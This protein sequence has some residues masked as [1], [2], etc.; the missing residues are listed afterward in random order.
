MRINKEIFRLAIP[1]IITNITIPLLG[2]IDITIA[3]HMGNASFI[4]AIAV[5]AMMFNLVY[6]NMAFL[7]MGT[8][9]LTA[10][11]FGK[12]DKDGMKYILLRSSLIGLLIGLLIIALQYPLQWI[13]LL[14]ISPSNEVIILAQKY[15]YICVWGAPAILMTMAIKGW[16]LGMQNSKYP[17]YISIG[18]NIL[19]IIIS[20]WAV[21]ILEL[22]FIGI[23]IGTVVA[24]YLGI[25]FALVLLHKKYKYII[26]DINWSKCLRGND[27]N[28]FFSVNRDIFIR[29]LCLMSVTLFFMAVGARSGDLILAVNALIMQLFVMFSYFMDGFAFAGEA[30]VGRFAGA[31]NHI[32]IKLTIRNLFYWATIITVIFVIAY[33]YGN[34]EIFGFLTDDNSI[35]DVA[36]NYTCWIVLIP[37]AGVSAFIWDG[38]FIGLTATKQMV[39]SILAATAMFFIAFFVFPQESINDRLWLAFILYLAMR[40]ISQWALY[41]FSIRSNAQ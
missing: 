32:A 33:G 2:L 21:F 9:G 16:L 17:M 20:L 30:L 5:G 22:G 10:Q 26:R 7:R 31:K 35:I 23:A 27:I 25:I 15:F 29:S 3:G 19:N 18:V 6:W 37:I 40:S 39:F 28:K 38:V 14:A 24:E 8:T 13:A 34:R 4:G 41:S 36:S 11:S 1:A 12:G